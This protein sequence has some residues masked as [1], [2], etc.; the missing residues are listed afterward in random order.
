M[1]NGKT[2]KIETERNGGGGGSDPFAEYM[3]HWRVAIVILS[4]GVDGSEFSLE[5]RQVSVGRS[6][7][8]EIAIEDGSMSKEHA[9]FEFSDNGFRVR[10]LGSMNGTL[11]NGSAI[12]VAE[13]K[14]GDRI[15][16]GEHTFQ[17][18]LEKRRQHPR[19]YVLPDA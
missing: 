7:N 19:T 16:M 3:N 8:N 4:G 13:L 11:L 1:R 10:D 17:L 9:V 6:M 2:R 15:Q 12:R 14:H 5:Q 18:V